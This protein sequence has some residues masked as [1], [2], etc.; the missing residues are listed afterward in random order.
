MVEDSTQDANHRDLIDR[1]REGED[2]KEAF[3]ELFEHYFPRLVSFFVRRGFG[4]ESARDLSQE[5]LFRVYKNRQDFRGA[6]LEGWLFKIAENLGHKRFRYRNAAK[7]KAEEVSLDAEPFREPSSP[8]TSPLGQTLEREKLERL[9]KAM[10]ELPPKRRRVFQLFVLQGFSTAEV[11]S[12]LG[13]APST[14]KVHVHHAREQLRE[15][16]VDCLS[17]SHSEP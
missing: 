1:L 2:S 9:Q 7:R 6:S 3:R 5:T 16:L 12:L 14:V 11:A 15:A 4:Y 8:Q 10:V 17:N 13:I